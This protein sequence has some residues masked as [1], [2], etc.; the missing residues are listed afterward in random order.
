[1]ARHKEF[2]KEEAL[3]AAMEIF[4][5]HG[6]E[7]SSTPMLTRAMRIGRQSLYDTF[8]DK[9]QLYLSALSRYGRLEISAHVTTLM[10]KQKAMDGITAMIE[11]VVSEARQSCLGV[12]SVCEFGN[13]EKDVNS[14]HA[15]SDRLLRAA[16]VGRIEEAQSDGDLARDL[17]PSSVVDF[18]SASF[19]GIRIAA[20]SGAQDAQLND[21]GKMA[22]RAIH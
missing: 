2:D 16:L 19:A 17:N 5:E 7:G 8:G 10:S 15:S 4:R 13:R 9:W 12:N 18:L 22:V 14:I 21:L 3:A 20:R 1:M 6:F 11:R